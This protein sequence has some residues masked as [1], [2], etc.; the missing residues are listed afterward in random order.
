[1]PVDELR[2]TL[3]ELRGSSEALARRLHDALDDDERRLL[4]R[5]L[6]GVR[7]AEEVLDAVIA[8]QLGEEVPRPARVE[9]PR[10]VQ[11]TREAFLDDLGPGD[12][13]EVGDL[14]Q[15]VVADP[16]MLTAVVRV[17]VQNAVKFVHRRPHTVGIRGWEDAEGWTVEVTDT[18]PG[19][20]DGEHEQIFALYDERA[21][22]REPGQGI[23]LSACRR[24]VE[25]HGGR[26]WARTAEGGGTLVAFTLPRADGPVPAAP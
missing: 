22:G 13:I 20:A 3:S 14:P 17:L 8:Y 16:R 21:D 7:R 6:R 5:T 1:M 11:A 9:L 19:V 25:A 24:L 2:H 4:E 26:I 12:R 23:G 18:G 10:V 15:H